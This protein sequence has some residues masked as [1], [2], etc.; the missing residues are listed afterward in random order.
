MK[1]QKLLSLFVGGVSFS[2]LACHAAGG[3]PTATEKRVYDVLIDNKPAGS[4]TLVLRQS[5]DGVLDVQ[6]QAAVDFPFFLHH[7]KYSYNGHEVWKG[8]QLSA[9]D[10]TSND[11]G[12]ACTV[13]AAKQNDEMHV[14]T[15]GKDRLMPRDVVTSS[16]WRLP[17]QSAGKKEV[18]F[19]EVDTGEV[20]KAVFNRLGDERLAIADKGENCQHYKLSGDDK[21]ELWYDGSQRLVRQSSKDQGHTTVIQLKTKTPQ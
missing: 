15:N 13:H 6:S 18:Q 17:V 14:K 3:S 5:S 10:S 1:N 12:K 8:D 4:Y 9:F 20:F 21:T 11:D 19:L 2:V 16:Y 7:Y